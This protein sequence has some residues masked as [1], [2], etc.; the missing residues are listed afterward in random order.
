[1]RQSG[2][3]MQSARLER[4]AAPLRQQVVRAL[5]EDILSG[6]Y[7]PGERLFENGL[8][9]TYSVSRTVIREALR[10]LESE[11]LITMLPGRGPIATELQR[12]DIDSLYQVR[13]ALEGLTGE[14]FAIYASDEQALKLA[15]HRDV[16]ERDYR[17]G[18]VK[19]RET[20]KNRF[21]E[22]LLD[23]A[24]ND[25]LASNLWGIH[26]RIGIFRR[27][28]FVDEMRVDLS[29]QELSAIITA[30]AIERDPVLAREACEH[31]IRQAGELAVISY[32]A[33]REAGGSVPALIEKSREAA[34]VSK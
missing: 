20:S 18:T 21:Y 34:G 33:W 14:L 2:D 8:C 31:H 11:S 30:A 12:H 7:V 28:A 15:G 1:M 26:S 19:S 17:H 13:R 29:M 16:L 23:G 4:H 6:A 5:R 22:L 27:L 25:A 24:G 10:Q 3:R 9:E 32:L